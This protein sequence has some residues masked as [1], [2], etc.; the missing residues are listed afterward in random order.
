MRISSQSP[1][2]A[3]RALQ[4]LLAVK[5]LGEIVA[6]EP[7]EGRIRAGEGT[8]RLRIIMKPAADTEAIRA[9]LQR[10][11]EIEEVDIKKPGTK[12]GSAGQRATSGSDNGK[13]NGKANDRPGRARR[14]LTRTGP[15]GSM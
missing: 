8:E 11:S 13:K 1:M 6:L 5:E 4:A 2:P 14:G 9:A 12:N 10:I 3:V 15:F 7:D